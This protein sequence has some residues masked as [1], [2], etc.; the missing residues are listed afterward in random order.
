MEKLIPTFESHFP[1][2]K[3]YLEE[4]NQLVEYICT[5]TQE[6][7]EGFLFKEIKGETPLF[8]RKDQ[9][10][11]VEVAQGTIYIFNGF[12][13]DSSVALLTKKG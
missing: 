10:I 4:N 7:K 9:L 13:S 6:G 8:V 3:D 11:N 12:F 1:K 5:Y 2:N